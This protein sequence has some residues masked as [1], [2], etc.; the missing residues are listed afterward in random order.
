[1]STDIISVVIGP[2]CPESAVRQHRQ[3]PSF[4]I[5]WSHDN[6]YNVVF[7][8]KSSKG[9]F[10]NRHLLVYDMDGVL[11]DV[12]RSYRDVARQTV[13][14]LIRTARGGDRLPDPLFSL[15]DLAAVKQSGGLN[16]DWD[17]T[18]TL[19]DLLF[20]RIDISR[21]PAGGPD[22]WRYY[23]ETMPRLDVNALAVFLA[24]ADHPLLQLR[25]NGNH[26][27]SPYVARLC[28]HDVG[29]GNVVKQV[30]QE[31]YLGEALFMKTYGFGPRLYRGQGY[32]T[33]E[34]LFVA[35]H[36]LADLSRH[37]I[38][39]VATGRPRSEA[40]FALER[41]GLMRLF[42]T[43]YTL[44][45]CLTAEEDLYQRTGKRQHLGKPHPFMLDAVGDQYA[46]QVKKCCYFGD[47]PDDM[48]AAARSKHPFVP[49]GCVYAAAD[50][51]A[52]VRTLRA[53]GAEIIVRTPEE[54]TA[55]RPP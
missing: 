43:V 37:H 36:R 6:R 49:V 12:S 23:T 51:S 4:S 46:H 45:D 7:E 16:N 15:S 5:S 21:L 47:M 32:I 55:I 11:V 39:G 3:V 24:T 1:M 53:A 27:R 38:L 44:E 26:R 52:L 18:Y 25:R 14:R 35:Q 48:L 9:V 13:Y 29:S 40:L 8:K 30:F 41:H 28:A 2:F 20:S 34:R 50:K 17:L 10:V 54:L 22:P 31:I 33:R 42:Q 19:L